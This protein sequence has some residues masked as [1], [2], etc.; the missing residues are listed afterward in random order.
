M[1]ELVI[2]SEHIKRPLTDKEIAELLGV[3]RPMVTKLATRALRKMRE[4]LQDTDEHEAHPE[5]FQVKE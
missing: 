5:W 3:S 1:D 4:Q 2:A